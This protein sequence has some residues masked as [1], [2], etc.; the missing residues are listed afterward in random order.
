MDA[1]DVM[2]TTPPS[3]PIYQSRSNLTCSSSHSRPPTT[4]APSS[5]SPPRDARGVGAS[6]LRSRAEPQ[7][8]LLL[9]C[10]RGVESH[11]TFGTRTL[12]ASSWSRGVARG[13]TSIQ[14]RGRSF[15]LSP[16]R[17]WWPLSRSRR[18][19]FRRLSLSRSARLERL[20]KSPRPRG[21]SP[22]GSF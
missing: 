5:S 10:D 14:L 2:L 8:S 6:H 17:V 1:T 3:L 4:E 7:P 9:A 16:L 13:V 12:G 20:W 18:S 15:P 21:A 19:S 11:A 22:L